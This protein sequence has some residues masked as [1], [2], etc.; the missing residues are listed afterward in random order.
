MIIV[1]TV[2]KYANFNCKSKCYMI[3]IYLKYSAYYVVQLMRS[4][5][6]DK[7][8]LSGNAAAATMQNDYCFMD[9]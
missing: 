1:L 6:L 8:R 2:K 3:L 4:T 9:N 5:V 7:R